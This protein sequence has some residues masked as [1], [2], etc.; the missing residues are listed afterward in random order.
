MFFSE[1]YIK[2][3]INKE[4]LN[5]IS[6][7][8]NY[9]NFPIISSFKQLVQ[10]SLEIYEVSCKWNRPERRKEVKNVRTLNESE[11]LD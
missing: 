3:G 11:D 1:A 4:P 2:P 10:R 7:Y 9:L 8:A 5:S 6:E